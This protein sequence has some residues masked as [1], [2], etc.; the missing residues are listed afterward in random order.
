MLLIALGITA[1]VLKSYDYY[2]IKTVPAPKP[3]FDAETPTMRTFD[4]Y[5]FTGVHVQQYMREKGRLVWTDYYKDFDV[6]SGEYG[7][8]IDFHLETPPPK[9]PHE[10][11]IILTGGSGAQGWG[12][13][14]NADMFYKKLPLVLMEKLKKDR[15]SCSVNVIN[16]AMGGTHIYQNFIALNKWGHRLAPDA[17]I[18]FS[19][20]NEIVV[21]FSTLSD[22][23]AGGA[24]A[25]SLIYATNYFSSP[26]WLKKMAEYLPG[27][28]RRTR[29]G[30][31]VRSAYA[32]DYLEAWKA[33]YI[34]NFHDPDAGTMDDAERLKRS[35]K[36]KSEITMD[37]LDKKISTP[38]YVHSL[39]SM[40]RDYPGIPV[41]AVFQPMAATPAIYNRLIADVTATVQ[42][43]GYKNVQFYN[44]QKVWR[45]NNYYPGSFIT[46]DGVHLT[47]EGHTI[48]ANALGEELYPFVKSRCTQLSGTAKH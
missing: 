26:P 37:N 32:T 34:I 43:D 29:F 12:G 14:T 23:D 31:I 40:A 16:L 33:K 8:F 6:V 3:D 11:R 48:A 1:L 25:G 41:F 4:Y 24:T 27:I 13:R 28:V 30:N 18:S 5:P 15:A 36:I 47:N 10:I 2:L 7:F 20:H 38:L 9:D 44:L 42:K 17:I 39:E 21:P 45:D 22:G 35:Q 46:S 19:G